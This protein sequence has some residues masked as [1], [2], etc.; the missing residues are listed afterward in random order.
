MTGL[1]RA[2]SAVW[3]CT[4]GHA[5]SHDISTPDAGGIR[6]PHGRDALGIP[7]ERRCR[8]DRSRPSPIG[9]ASRKSKRAGSSASTGTQLGRDQPVGRHREHLA[10]GS[11]RVQSSTCPSPAT[12]YGCGP[13]PQGAASRTLVASPSTVCV[14]PSASSENV[15]STTMRHGYAGLRLDRRREGH[16]ARDPCRSPRSRATPRARAGRD[17]APAR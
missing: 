1:A 2:R 7:R 16:V 14:R 6:H 11:S 4:H 13:V 17:R 9:R 3:I 10:A 8:R 12:R 15:V 5:A